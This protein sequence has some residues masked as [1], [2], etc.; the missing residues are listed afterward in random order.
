[1]PRLLIV[2]AEDLEQRALP[3]A[4]EG[5]EL[6]YAASGEEAIRILASPG[7]ADLAVIELMMPGV[8]G[9]D[10]ARRVRREFPRV[11]IVLTSVYHLSARQLELAGCEAAGFVPKPYAIGELCGL[12]R[13]NPRAASPATC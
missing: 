12:L 5:L 4:A 2:D 6:A 8:N 11:R 7:S 13:S 9:L 3:G 1:M 10:L